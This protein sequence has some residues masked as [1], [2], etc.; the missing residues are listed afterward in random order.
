MAEDYD[1][2]TNLPPPMKKTPK[3]VN[4]SDILTLNT[5]TQTTTA[6]IHNNASISDVIS[7][8]TKNLTKFYIKMFLNIK[9]KKQLKLR[10]QKKI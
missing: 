9:K 6:V 5:D 7:D 1:R 8:Y 10:R 3:K 2:Y 4:L